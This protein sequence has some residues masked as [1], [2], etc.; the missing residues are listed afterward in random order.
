M[1]KRVSTYIL[2][3]MAS[4]H[5]GDLK[6]AEIMKKRK[7]IN[8][9]ERWKELEALASKYRGSNGDYYD[10]IIT[11]SAGQKLENIIGITS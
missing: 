5:E 9:D 4:S 3:E 6:T 8:W 2:A 7:S 1:K 11:V 10:C